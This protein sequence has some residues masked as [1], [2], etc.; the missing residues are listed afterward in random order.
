MPPW[1][2]GPTAR[3]PLQCLL[4]C[5]EGRTEATKA[6]Q[7]PSGPSPLLLPPRTRGD[8]PQ[9]DNPRSSEI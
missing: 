7:T 1:F 9:L 3:L 6:P 5:G 4:R 2:P 8:R